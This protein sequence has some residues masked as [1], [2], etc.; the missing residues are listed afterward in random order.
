MNKILTWAV[1]YQ[2]LKFIGGEA[3]QVSSAGFGMDIDGNCYVNESINTIVEAAIVERIQRPDPMMGCLGFDYCDNMDG[4]RSIG[5]KL[6]TIT[7]DMF[8]EIVEEMKQHSTSKD[9][10]EKS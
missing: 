9:D 6:D 7:P 5:V 3:H 8:N 2:H 4:I 1:N 10:E